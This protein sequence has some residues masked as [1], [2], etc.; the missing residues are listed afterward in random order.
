MKTRLLI[1]KT[2]TYGKFKLPFLSFWYSINNF[3][4]KNRNFYEDMEFIYSAQEKKIIILNPKVATRSLIE[5]ALNDPTKKIV[6]NLRKIP[7]YSGYIIF[8]VRD[9]FDRFVSFWD[10]KISNQH[11]YYKSLL[12]YK[13][14]WFHSDI[15]IKDFLINLRNTDPNKFEKHF[16]LQVAIYEFLKKFNREITIIDIS[17]VSK[18][19]HSKERRENKTSHI[20][21]EKT[22]EI[23]EESK[24]LFKDVYAADLRFHRDLK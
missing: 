12:Y 15:E 11:K 24:D 4:K 6:K 21:K 1:E 19:T 13:Y 18:V 8:P 23:F 10:D 20:Q 14:S 16:C 3:L 17:D 7:K 5:D 22:R 2:I 9:P